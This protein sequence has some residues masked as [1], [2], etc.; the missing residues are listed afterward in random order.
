[1]ISYTRN[2]AVPIQNP[3]RILCSKGSERYLKKS[4]GGTK[5]H[6]KF[7]LATSDR[8]LHITIPTTLF[9]AFSGFE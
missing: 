1:M 7:A 2:S 5:N 4:S 6:R 3:R 9:V 8:I